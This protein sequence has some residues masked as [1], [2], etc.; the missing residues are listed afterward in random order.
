MWPFNSKQY[1]SLAKAVHN[2][3]V[4]AVREMLE[5][6]DDPNSYDPDFKVH[7][8]HFAVGRLSW[9]TADYQDSVEIVKLL[10]QHGANV[11]IPAGGRMPLWVAEAGKHTEVA[12]ILR[13]AGARLRADDDKLVLAPA[14]EREIRKVAR[15]FAR[16]LRMIR[17]DYSKEQL[18]EAVESKIVIQPDPHAS[19]ADYT[20]FKEQIRLVIRDE[21]GV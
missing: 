4:R 5:R 13:K 8:I 9:E 2:G 20:R 15:D 10:V 14:K 11:N 19:A 12:A 3:D 16:Q 21:L 7:A 17:P 1:P 18:A 6:G